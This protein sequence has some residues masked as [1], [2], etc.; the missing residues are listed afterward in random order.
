M[1]HGQA[2]TAAVELWLLLWGYWPLLQI[3]RQEL[4]KLCI[5]KIPAATSAGAVRAAVAAAVQKAGQSND[6][7]AAVEAAGLEEGAAGKQLVMLVLKHPG[8]ANDVFSALPGGNGNSAIII[9]I[10][11]MVV[12]VEEWCSERER[13]E[14]RGDG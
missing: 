4:A 13:G 5:H 3:D 6:A 8:Q 14:G 9:I 11:I 10:I 1:P 12:V 7:V 2:V